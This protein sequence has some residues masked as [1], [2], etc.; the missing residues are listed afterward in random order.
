MSFRK[1]L[2][3]IHLAAG[4]LAGVSIAIMSL[5]G[6]TLAFEKEL[7]VWSERAVRVISIPSEPA[8]SIPV[9]DLL[10]RVQ[11]QY[12]N[13]SPVAVIVSADPQQAIQVSYGR[14][15]TYFVNPFTGEI[16]EPNAPRMRA[17]LQT[18]LS[19]HRWLGRE[20][21]SRDTGKAL[22]GASNLIFLGLA[23]TGIYLWWPRHW[24][25]MHLRAVTF[26]TLRGRGRARDWN[27]HNA[28]GLWS[29]PVLIVL[30][31]T[32][33]PISYRWAGDLIYILTGTRQ[34]IARS[35]AP[36]SPSAE[37]QPA[38][39]V[40]HAPLGYSALLAR[41]AEH[42]PHWKQMTLRLSSTPPGVSRSSNTS[43]TP[44]TIAVK[45]GAGTPRFATRNLMLDP[46]VGSILRDESFAHLDLARQVRSWTR[47]LHTGEALGPVGQ[48]AAGLASAAAGILVWT[49]LALTW[50]RFF[51]RRL[52]VA[53]TQNVP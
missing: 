49:G 23:I 27:W 3:W 10:A 29:A 13:G 12:T 53:T 21:E 18:M 34:A 46:V 25:A 17:F 6:A 15:H 22:T 1:L 28:I 45:E 52:A 43:A 26:P 8:A 30:T 37:S 33:L 35:T 14:T 51:R 11:A 2:F 42:V 38:P 32:A 5:T 4:V 48:A 50:R 36:G 31:V 7:L 40:Q 41:A 47:Y 16:R 19:W 44:V 39:T 24:T 9:E 20:G